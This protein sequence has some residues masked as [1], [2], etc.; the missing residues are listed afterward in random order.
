[1]CVGGER[2]VYE[3]IKSREDGGNIFHIP[4]WVSHHT[5]VVPLPLFFAS[6]SESFVCAVM[7][8]VLFGL[9]DKAKRK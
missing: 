5:K 4:Q 1:M 3:L 9:P 6:F 2:R 7:F 8:F